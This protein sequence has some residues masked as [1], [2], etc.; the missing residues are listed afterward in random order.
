[1]AGEINERKGPARC[2]KTKE[3]C[4]RLCAV[5]CNWRSICWIVCTVAIYTVIYLRFSPM[6]EKE[7]LTTPKFDAQGVTKDWNTAF[8]IVDWERQ[9]ISSFLMPLILFGIGVLTFLHNRDESS[10]KSRSKVP[11]QAAIT[12]LLL[13]AAL[14]TIGLGLRNGWW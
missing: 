3:V 9:Y 6:Q 13:C 8:Q 14:M 7:Y 2:A 11:I 10:T 5:L 12:M 4:K 1:M